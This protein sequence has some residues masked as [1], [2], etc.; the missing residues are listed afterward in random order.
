MKKILLLLALV[1]GAMTMVAQGDVMTVNPDEPVLIERDGNRYYYNYQVMNSKECDAFLAKNKLPI[2]NEF[3]HA[4]QLSRTGW[5]LLGV[6]V[7]LDCLGLGLTIGSFFAGGDAGTIAMMTTG[8]IC[9]VA[10]GCC[11]IACIPVLV[12][13]YTRMQNCMDYYYSAE[14]S[15]RRVAQLSLTASVNGLGLALKF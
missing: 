7:G 11:E 6:G 8:A 12:V 14:K 10:G 3:H 9:C 2:Y 13:G 1:M 15:K 4:Y 5:T